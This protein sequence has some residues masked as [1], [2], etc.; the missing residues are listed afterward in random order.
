MTD[1]DMTDVPSGSGSGTVK[2][3]LGKTKNAATESVSDGKK[4]FEVKKV[5]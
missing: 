2:K 5:G 1:I 3:N 4:R